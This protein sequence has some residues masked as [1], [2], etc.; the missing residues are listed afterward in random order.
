MEVATAD[1]VNASPL[2]P[3]EEAGLRR[4][5]RRS[6]IGFVPRKSKRVAVL[7]DRGEVSVAEMDERIRGLSRGLLEVVR[8]WPVWCTS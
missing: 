7:V 2:P 1:Q 8:E 4:V 6:M 3:R 5:E